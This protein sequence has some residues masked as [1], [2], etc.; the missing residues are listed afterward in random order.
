MEGR[1]TSRLSGSDSPTTGKLSP[2]LSLW[3]RLAMAKTVWELRVA[4]REILEC[5]ERIGPQGLNELWEFYCERLGAIEAEGRG[6]QGNDASESPRKT[7]KSRGERS[8]LPRPRS[9]RNNS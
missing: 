2:F 4:W 7:R 6:F 1:K 8:Q 9:C 3:N 5:G